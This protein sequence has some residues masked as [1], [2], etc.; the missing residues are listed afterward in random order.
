MLSILVSILVVCIIFGLLWWVI[1]LLPLAPPFGQIVRVVFA[2]ICV[3]WLLY[4]LV[5]YATFGHP[6]PLR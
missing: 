6:Y 2:V 5:P 1:S 4:M 3:I